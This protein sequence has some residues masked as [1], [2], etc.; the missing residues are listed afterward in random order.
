VEQKNR[1]QRRREKFGRAGKVSQHDPVGP[2]P[3]SEANPALR[4]ATADEAADEG[5]A[6][7]EAAA[8]DATADVESP[9]EDVPPVADPP[10]EPV[11]AK[12]PATKPK[13]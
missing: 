7:D 6:A 2:W 11:G 8:A 5:A 9:D 13:S 3:D 10:P 1:E 12:K 4:N